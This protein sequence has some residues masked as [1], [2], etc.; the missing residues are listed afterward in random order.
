MNS[1]N[2]FRRVRWTE[3][4]H[5]IRD[6][7]CSGSVAYCMPGTRFLSSRALG[8]IA[9]ML[10]AVA[11][12]GTQR[13]PAQ[14]PTN[15]AANSFRFQAVAQQA[16]QAPQAPST[17]SSP[18]SS[19]PS[20]APSSAAGAVQPQGMAKAPIVVREL[21]VPFREINA[22]LER[23]PER[24]FLERVEFEKLL[25]LARQA[26][27]RRNADATPNTNAAT[28]TSTN[29]NP[30]APVGATLVAADYSGTFFEGR[31][32]IA[33]T[34][35]IESASEGWQAVTLEMPGMTLRAAALAGQPAAL[36]DA[37]PGKVIVFVQ[38]RGRH[39]LTLDMAAPLESS[40]ALQ[41]LAGHLP[42]APA[43]RL[44][45]AVPGN[46]E[47]KSGAAVVSREVDAAANVTRF[48]LLPAA[49][50][51]LVLTLN[52]RQLAEQRLVIARGVLVD[53]L[54]AGYERLHVTMALR[55]VRGAA[56]GFRFRLPA[57]FE[58][59]EVKSPQL[60][61]WSVTAA[62]NTLDVRL[63][64]AARDQVTIEIVATRPGPAPI[65]WTFPRL[66][67]LDVAGHSAVLG[68]LAEQP[69][70]VQ[71]LE[72]TGLLPIDLGV[73]AKAL[74]ATVATVDP[75][76]P[77]VRPIAAFYAPQTG[78]SLRSQF[79]LP[80]PRVLA[81]GNL[82][83]Q[84]S[85]QLW[86]VAGNWG[87]VPE[88]DRLF[89]VPFTAP[90][91]WTITTVT[92]GDG[93]P[94]PFEVADAGSGRQRVRVTLPHAVAPGSAATVS[95]V[96]ERSPDGWLG[97]WKS[98]R[99]AFDYPVFAVVGAA[100]EDGALAIQTSDDFQVTPR[101]ADAFRGLAPLD[102][103]EKPNFGWAGVPTAL[104][105][106][107]AAHP[108]AASFEVERI[109]ARMTAHTHAF[110]KLDTA[111]T[112]ARYELRF[113]LREGKTSRLEIDLPAD[114][115]DAISIQGL[116]GTVVK[117]F[118]I[119]PATTTA[120]TPA[121]AATSKS[122]RATNTP[123]SDT[124]DQRGIKTDGTEQGKGTGKEWRRWWVQLAAPATQD[125]HV[126]I[127]FPQPLPEAGVASATWQLPI[128]RAAPS[129]VAYQS[130]FVAV[131]GSAELDIA[132]KINETGPGKPRK[133]D[134]G[135]LA[136]ADYVVGKR[137]LGA[138]G[139]VGETPELTVDMQRRDPHGLPT[140][141]VQ[142]AEL[143]TLLSGNGK[144]L[145]VARY[146]LRIRSSF[147]ELRLP[148]G[149]VLWA[150]QV[151][152]RPMAPQRVEVDG[153]TALLLSFPADPVSQRDLQVVYE[154]PS[155]SMASRGR[156]DT[157]APAL[158]LR[159]D[160]GR[161]TARVLEAE[162][163]WKV[164]LPTG[165]R[166]AA[167][168]GNVFPDDS[169]P[170]TRNLF[171]L[172][173]APWI[174]VAS[175]AATLTKD[176]ADWS[177][178]LDL[179]PFRR[180]MPTASFIRS[181][182]NV[183]SRSYTLKAAPA[184]GIAPMAE[185]FSGGMGGIGG[186]GGMGGGMGGPMSG[187]GAGPMGGMTSPDMGL[188]VDSEMGNAEMDEKAESSLAPGMPARRAG[189]FRG[190]FGDAAVSKSVPR[191]SAPADAPAEEAAP[192]KPRRPNRE[193]ESLELSDKLGETTSGQK[194]LASKADRSRDDALSLGRD[195]AVD[196]QA[197]L[198]ASELGQQGG[199]RSSSKGG[200]RSGGPTEPS[201][202][203]LTASDDELWALE[204]VRSLPFDFASFL[205][206]RGGDMLSLR[207]LGHQPRLD[208]S[209]VHQPS[210]V[211]LSWTLAI[212]L[213]GWGVVQTKAAATTRL[214]W[215]VAGF[216]ATATAPLL[217]PWNYE[218]G[219]LADYLFGSLAVL[220]A[221]YVLESAT[222]WFVRWLARRQVASVCQ[223]R[224]AQCVHACRQSLPLQVM[225]GRGLRTSRIQ[226]A[227]GNVGADDLRGTDGEVGTVSSHVTGSTPSTQANQARLMLWPLFLATALVFGWGTLRHSS[228]QAEEPTTK[229]PVTA[230]TP[231]SP[232]DRDDNAG[233][234]VT[235]PPDAILVPFDH[236]DPR[237]IE[238]AEKVI[239][240]YTQYVELWKRAYPD[241]KSRE[242]PPPTPFAWAGADYSARL[243]SSGDLLINGVLRVNV[244]GDGPVEVPLALAGGVLVSAEV[245]G[246]PARLRSVQPPSGPKQ[247]PAGMPANALPS[248]LS[249]APAGMP[250]LPP[251]LATLLLSGGGEKR[252]VLAL[253]MKQT[254][255]GGVRL[256]QAQLPAVP[257]ASL[258]LIAP[259][260]RTEVVVGAGA[261]AIRFET[262][263]VDERLEAA[264][265]RDGSLTLQWRPQ[266]SQGEVDRSL[267]T[268]SDAE[269]DVREDA[270]RVVWRTRLEFRG[271]QR[272]AFAFLL[273]ADY[274]VE[275]VLG[276]NVKGWQEKAGPAAP[277]VDVSLL[278]AATDR[279]ELTLILSRR[280]GIEF[281]KPSSYPLPAVA[282]E[283]AALQ[284][285]TV[286]L[287]RSIGLDVRVADLRGLTRA[288]LPGESLSERVQAVE[289]SPLGLRSVESLRFQ[290]GVY[291]GRLEVAPLPSDA[292]AE[293]RS[294]LRLDERQ[295]SLETQLMVRSPAKPLYQIRV[296]LPAGLEIELVRSPA[297]LEWSIVETA[298]KRTLLALLGAGQRGEVSVTIRGRLP[299]LTGQRLAL[300]RLAIADVTSQESDWAVLADPSFDVRPEQLRSCEPVLLDRV[301]GWLR[302]EQRQL[303]RLALQCRGS[304]YSGVLFL[305]P[306]ESRVASIAVAN[307]RVTGRSIAETILI[308]ARIEEAGIRQFVFTLPA[309]LRDARISAPLLRRKTIEPLEKTDDIADADGRVRVKL[310]LQD[311]VIGQFR[312]L[313]EHDRLVTDDL[314]PAPIPTIETGRTEQRFVTLE[315]LGRDELVVEGPS[316]LEPLTRQQQAWGKLAA[317]LGENILMAYQVTGD[318]VAPRLT[319]RPQK[320]EAVQ[321]AG[322]RIALSETEIV[323]DAAGAYRAKQTYHVDNGTEQF[324]VV[325][326]PAGATLWTAVVAGSPERPQRADDLADNT[327]AKG[328]AVAPNA[329]KNSP[330]VAANAPKKDTNK[331]SVPAAGSGSAGS[332]SAAS[333]AS[334]VTATGAT[335][336][337]IPLVKT[338]AG[339]LDYPVVLTYGGKMP[340]LGAWS[341]VRFPFL[342]TRNVNVELSRV[343]LR[344]PE[345]HQWPWFEGTLGQVRQQAEYEASWLEYQTGRIRKLL[346]TLASSKQ[347]A[348]TR[349]RSQSN[350]KQLGM[351]VERFQTAD[352]PAARDNEEYSRNYSAFNSAL[353]QSRRTIEQE[354]QA[355]AELSRQLAVDNRERLNGLFFQQENRRARNVVNQLDANF[356]DSGRRADSGDEFDLRWFEANGL[357]SAAP[358]NRVLLEDRAGA[359]GKARES[360]DG[361]GEGKPAVG[362]QFEQLQELRKSL[363][364][365]QNLAIDGAVPQGDAAKDTGPGRDGGPVS[366]SAA[367]GKGKRSGRAVD[368]ENEVRQRYRQQLDNQQ[369]QAMP[370]ATQS[371]LANGMILPSPSGA[372]NM[373]ATAPP[374]SQLAVPGAAGMPGGMP[375]MPGMPGV[376]GMPGASERP[377]SPRM[378][379]KPG[380][381]AVTGRLAGGLAGE[382]A[383]AM[384]EQAMA[385]DAGILTSLDVDLP[386]GG[387][388][389]LFRTPRGE[390]EIS[391]YAVSRPLAERAWR[392][393]ALVAVVVVV[394]GPWF[395]ASRRLSSRRGAVVRVN[396]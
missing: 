246:Q 3:R 276:E 41:T 376:A 242:L 86:R 27:A 21:F 323:V 170:V 35:S 338:A 392:L 52:N 138:F 380:E 4:T 202:D 351:A 57:H 261:A 174:N 161:G 95:F 81:T 279:E 365:R 43:S 284:Q 185:P 155:G 203:E 172:R 359:D 171:A 179:H 286:H 238:K 56:D 321:T 329:A 250:P 361:K 271:G 38:G 94:L 331:D 188:R 75:T 149:A 190:G 267:A 113:E 15:P 341:A 383:G 24:V 236:E 193:K 322:A 228:L 51:A 151:D 45:L 229:S 145:S 349:M 40:A 347:D 114:T 313:I 89:S 96:A 378:P 65:D 50:E 137:L 175:A 84:L 70:Q 7:A 389:Y 120:T 47:V 304:D 176:A 364:Q 272:D 337:R 221:W 254:S 9:S 283:G 23:A 77:L 395:W 74:P 2:S 163:L 387:R 37:G 336:V 123:G 16:S 232:G 305:A 268:T 158:F 6:A 212:L 211:A 356:A 244:L 299:T 344:L 285:G 316:G 1:S 61:R 293:L 166:V 342:K 126:A 335:L 164:R 76:A 124:D 144:V 197:A 275:R 19:S 320:R 104:A 28:S 196:P 135:E 107:Y 73:L 216:L 357:G 245:D 375:G 82:L 235:L 207:S 388:E 311:E 382:Q 118:G 253:R 59:T 128:A 218:L 143:V 30:N 156:I 199:D 298:G 307:V 371:P 225:G 280:V 98:P 210:L 178:S 260:A 102:D 92:G 63:A 326:L 119:A 195:A 100:R 42:L 200:E 79:K 136:G 270:I 22:L 315:S 214:R 129:S 265:P 29:T 112:Q 346:D 220:T 62:D 87:L 394:G 142:R 201:F 133:V 266:V 249:N 103:N 68:V 362:Q 160:A 256:V 10:W 31:A 369:L 340:D 192:G 259:E 391:A 297:P 227:S 153:E 91:G 180:L 255:R 263:A 167:R 308:D 148:A 277:R 66:E 343:R 85:P 310:D 294:V 36:G 318:S 330:T 83:L 99:Y 111:V 55:I 33:G 390:L 296:E 386:S 182:A 317:L 189:T 355:D 222:R 312:V 273:P 381:P 269:V 324:L 206:P 373:P 152:G 353:E 8:A 105:Y 177:D 34:L 117:E 110:L 288:E 287:R 125:A 264:L 150:A 325:E 234:P 194:E 46:V 384:P 215:L 252:I 226:T 303:A 58:V 17:P 290:T 121:T 278:K 159:D 157:A 339:D 168:G 67:P 44:R 162:L 115:P 239:V 90:A 366:Q 18:S 370:Q 130:G 208:L 108:Y 48:E 240:P 12:L 49:T 352:I 385:E 60:S 198:A 247:V 64:E 292:T 209:V 393:A 291:S 223:Q 233:P 116:R 72:S 26:D 224:I 274:Q 173:R 109:A 186:M 165:Y 314:Q 360:K 183:D 25:V 295:S 262:K 237:G 78:Y 71:S 281:G 327:G 32:R 396:S 97:E 334:I 345:T 368:T 14:Q 348:L 251:P 374:Q 191:F 300:P 13:A 187:S 181:F 184:P 358:M 350:L 122:I 372:A 328:K 147:L 306:R 106:R 204:G 282:A 243:A 309:W 132:V 289:L 363:G 231:A 332:G 80:E 39:T 101:D 5:S 302:P 146:A 53:E 319:Y 367:G 69:R 230:T 217:T 301:S 54:T 127:E 377:E 88:T 139:Y 333:A 93:K 213:V 154:Q 241:R 140:A 134:I 219:T 11:A 258:D 379:P 205:D 169:D 131:E 20:A 257:A 354:A 141:I 248:P